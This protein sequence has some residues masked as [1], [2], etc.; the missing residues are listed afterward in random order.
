MTPLTVACV[1]VKGPVPYGVEYVTKLQ[2]MVHRHLDR[3]HLF[4]SFTD[5]PRELPPSVAAVPIAT[6]GDEVPPNG[7]GYWAKL[8]LFN[9]ALG[10]RGRVLYLDLDSIVVSDL[11]PIIDFPAPLALTEDALVHERAHLDQ[12]RYGRRVVRRF[13]SS[14]MVWDA[15]TQDFLFD[16]FV[17]TDYLYYSTDQ[18]WIG[19]RAT[20]A[21]GMPLAWFPRISQLRPPWPPATK[22]VL[23]KKPKNHQAVVCW[24][25]LEEW[26]R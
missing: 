13:N 10:L 12:D 2:R 5:R 24:P 4:V 22:V 20:A 26:W 7:R 19:A 16:E 1:W 23:C 17:L 14:V 8:Q 6:L 18:D 25:E 15:G 3:P 9:Q 21:Q 11:A